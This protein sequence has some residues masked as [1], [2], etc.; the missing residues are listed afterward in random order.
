MGD[1]HFLE[2]FKGPQ[3]FSLVPHEEGGPS[4]HEK[5]KEAETVGVLV[6]VTYERGTRK[7]FA[8]ARRVLSP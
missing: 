6:F 8:A 2:M 7:L 1:L 4:G 5:V 3:V